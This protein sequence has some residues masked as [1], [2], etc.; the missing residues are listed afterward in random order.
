MN[1]ALIFAGGTGQRMNVKDMPKQFLPVHGKPIIIHTL[2]VFEQHKD[3]DYICVVSVESH[4]DY[5]SDLLKKHNISKVKWL[6]P[7]G[8]TGEVSRYNG[9]KAI[10][11]EYSD[12]KDAVVLIHDG[13]RPLISEQIITDN[14]VAVREYGNAITCAPV[15]ETV[16]VKDEHAN[17]LNTVDR[18]MC[19]LARAPQSFFLPE[20]F[21]AYQSVVNTSRDT[22]DS[23]TLMHNKGVVLHLVEGPVENIK[24]TTPLDYFLMKAIYDLR[25]SAVFA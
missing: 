4:L 12:Q 1:I 17:L 9:L 23:A 20:V 18:T 25:E 11:S 5:L 6:I 10:Y 13:V 19:R 8:H 2:D 21:E 24:I 16:V 15:T 22:I 3:I 7:G 14:I